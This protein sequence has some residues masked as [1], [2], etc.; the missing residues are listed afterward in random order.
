MAIDFLPIVE[1]PQAASAAEVTAPAGD[2]ERELTP[3]EIKTLEP[4]FREKGVGLPNLATGTV[5][6]IV[7]NGEVV[8]F[9]VMQLKLHAQPVWV[10]KGRGS[11]LSRLIHGMEEFILKRCGPQW[12]YLFTEAG[13][14]STIASRFGMATEPWVVHSKLIIPDLPGRIDL[15]D[16]SEPDEARQ[17]QL[18][19]DETGETIQ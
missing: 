4:I 1:E 11:L 19:L 18:P 8:A 15:E 7:E 2:G 14:M 3:E 6:G 16:M 13:K 5:Y 10:K 9:M 12:V 17:G